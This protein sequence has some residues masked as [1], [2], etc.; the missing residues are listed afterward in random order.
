MLSK[1]LNPCLTSLIHD[2]GIAYREIEKSKFVLQVGD[3]L[4]SLMSLNVPM[5]TAFLLMVS[6]V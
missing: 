2:L 6:E 3:K 5:T 4:I 1:R